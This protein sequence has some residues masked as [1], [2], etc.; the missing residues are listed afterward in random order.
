M[1]G[2]GAFPISR[3]RAARRARFLPIALALCLAPAAHA[4]VY[5]NFYNGPFITTTAIS[6]F[7][8][9]IYLGS[10]RVYDG[11]QKLDGNAGGALDADYPIYFMDIAPRLTAMHRALGFIDI[12]VSCDIDPLTVPW[13]MYGSTDQRN[14]ND[15]RAVDGSSTLW[16]LADTNYRVIFRTGNAGASLSYNNASLWLSTT[17]PNLGA[18]TYVARSGEF[19]VA[20]F[21]VPRNP[22]SVYGIFLGKQNIRTGPIGAEGGTTKTWTVKV[23]VF[24][25]AIANLLIPRIDVI[26]PPM[27]GAWISVVADSSAFKFAPTRRIQVPAN[28][29]VTFTTSN[30]YNGTGAPVTNWQWDVNGTGVWLSGSDTITTTYGAKGLYNVYV[31]LAA[32]NV[33]ATN[34]GEPVDSSNNFAAQRP[35]LTPSSLPLYLEVID[36]P[37]L[38][39]LSVARPAPFV[40]GLE[41]EVQWDLALDAAV[42][43]CS[44]TIHRLDGVLVKQLWQTQMPQGLW[45]VRW[46]GTDAKGNLVGEGIYY[47]RVAAGA[48]SFVRKCH[49]ARLL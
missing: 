22:A 34:N 11:N 6:N 44:A 4:F 21:L 39:S 29:P 48:Q 16:P 33:C 8:W 46:D 47:L 45:T 28:V 25:T 38:K 24:T 13:R 37:G 5:T 32:S 42:P 40:I 14:D 17:N 10:S 12:L 7:P 27:D 43:D 3:P 18:H 9:K 23:H 30:S 1:G 35:A 19:V 49:V 15:L 41:P 36:P 31:R 20:R 2:P 26:G